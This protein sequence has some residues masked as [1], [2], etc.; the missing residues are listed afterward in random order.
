ME[1]IHNNLPIWEILLL[2]INHHD[3]ITKFQL[4]A[5]VTNYHGRTV[6]STSEGS[7]TQGSLEGDSLDF[8]Q[9]KSTIFPEE[10]RPLKN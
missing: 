8:K 3:I 7:S 1:H 6:H 10:R 2:P 4:P 5:S 9:M